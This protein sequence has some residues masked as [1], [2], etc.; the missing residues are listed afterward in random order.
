MRGLIGVGVRVDDL[1]AGLVV[2]VHIDF[3]LHVLRPCVVLRIEHIFRIHRPIVSTVQDSCVSQIVHTQEASH[4]LGHVRGVVGQSRGLES[5]LVVG[6][7][8]SS[9]EGG[10]LG[11]VGGI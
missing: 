11:W 5:G 8:E 9:L 6:K 4:R 2:V 10:D 1:H 7:V 3:D